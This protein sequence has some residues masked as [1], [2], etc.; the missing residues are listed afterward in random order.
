MVACLATNDNPDKYEYSGYS[1]GFNARSQFSWSDSSWGENIVI[2]G[3]Y[4][5]SSVHVGNKEKRYLSSW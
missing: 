1:I 4:N 2:F 3:V 5:S